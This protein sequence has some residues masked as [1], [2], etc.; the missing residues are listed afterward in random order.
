[1]IF[2]EWIIFILG[3]GVYIIWKSDRNNAK[4]NKNH[5][6]QSKRKKKMT[7]LDELLD[8]PDEFFKSQRK[9]G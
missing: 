3:V 8:N 5:L 7:E 9:K 4:D 2:V 6:S 1:M